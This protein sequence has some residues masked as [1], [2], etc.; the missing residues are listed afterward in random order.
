MGKCGSEFRCSVTQSVTL[1]PCQDFGS[2]NIFEVLVVCDDIN[3]GWS[4]FEVMAPGL[5]HFEDGW[6]FLVMHIVV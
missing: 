3:W 5:E 2:G 6:E 4:S 1:P